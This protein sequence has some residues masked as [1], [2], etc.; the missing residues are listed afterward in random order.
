MKKF[1]LFFASLMLAVTT[2]A[3]TLPVEG[4]FSKAIPE[5]WTYLTNNPTYPDPNF[6][7]AGGLKMGFE[8]QGIASPV[9]D[10][11]DGVKVTFTIASLN[12]N[13][14][15]QGDATDNFLVKAYDASGAILGEVG[16]SGAAEVGEH[17]IEVNFNGIA[18]IEFYMTKYISIDG[19]CRN[20]E[21]SAIK[22][23][24]K[25]TTSTDN[26]IENEVTVFTANNCIYVNGITESSLVEVYSVAGARVIAQTVENNEA[27]ACGELNRGV[28]IVR[29]NG[30]ASKVT[31]R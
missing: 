1:T 29:V 23:E 5:G 26:T 14:K 2:F 10:A 9:F 22:V 25:N 24:S 7:S 12:E 21:L 28:Y 31:L 17:S 15:S 30:K 8:G 11:V 18:K 4:T 27:I 3:A 20:T 13:T 16:F 6:Y 19:V